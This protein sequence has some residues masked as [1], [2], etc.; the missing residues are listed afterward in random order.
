MRE[1]L[2]HASTCAE[3]H[4]NRVD[5]SLARRTKRRLAAKLGE[6][7]GRFVS[8]RLL[9]GKAVEKRV[10]TGAVD[11]LA[12]PLSRRFLE[13]MSLVDHE[14]VELGE[15]TTPHFSIGEQERVIDHHQV[16]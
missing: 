10:E 7:A 2:V 1:H 5:Q 8:A 3:C 11:L 15:E 9:D 12:E 4:R 16:R 13:V 14:V 6:E